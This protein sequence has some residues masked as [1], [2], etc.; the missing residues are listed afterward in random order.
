MRPL[1][2]CNQRNVGVCRLKVETVAF[3]LYHNLRNWNNLVI[4]VCLILIG[5][6]A[7]EIMF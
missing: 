3:S 1:G 4:L 5:L 7:L 2:L 6:V